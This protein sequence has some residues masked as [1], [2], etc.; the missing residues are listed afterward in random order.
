MMAS[1]SLFCNSFSN[2]SPTAEPTPPSSEMSRRF[3]EGL[4]KDYADMR[5]TSLNQIQVLRELVALKGRLIQKKQ[6]L[7]ESN[8]ALKQLY[9]QVRASS[10]GGGARHQAHQARDFI[11]RVEENLA[12]SLEQ[13]TQE[14]TAYAERLLLHGETFQRDV[15][16]TARLAAVRDPPPMQGNPYVAPEEAMRHAAFGEP[17]LMQENLHV[18]PDE[19]TVPVPQWLQ[20]GNQHGLHAM[21]P[22]TSSAAQSSSWRREASR[23]SGGTIARLEPAPEFGAG[24]DDV[25][26]VGLMQV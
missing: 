23:P 14:L 16:W 2:V 24:P 22:P 12:T 26:V 21:T 6:N 1:T 3:V 15:D 13:Q 10:Q 17:R 7:T 9:A 19:S 4:E 11:P 8:T 18:G 20:T 25:L 5:S